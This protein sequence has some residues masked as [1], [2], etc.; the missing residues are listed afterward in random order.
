MTISLQIHPQLTVLGGA[1]KGSRICAC[2]FFHQAL[3][4][5]TILTNFCAQTIWMG[6][7]L[8]PR[9]HLVELDLLCD[10]LLHHPF[11]LRPTA[12]NVDA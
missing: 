5:I 1:C 12:Q 11:Y 4:S 8:H 3:D 10:I 9:P 6:I 2:H 7:L